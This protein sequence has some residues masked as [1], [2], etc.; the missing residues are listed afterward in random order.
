MS[1]LIRADLF[2][3]GAVIR[4]P[5]GFEKG[6]WVGA[7]GAF[8]SARERALYLTY[9]IRRPRG[10]APDRGGEARIARSTDF[11]RFEDVWSVT[12]DQFDTASIERCAVHQ[13]DD[14]QWRYFLSMVDPADGR[15]CVS[16][17]HASSP[18]SFEPARARRLF[19]A[20]EL[21]LEGA[22]DPWIRKT[23]HGFSMYLSVAV[24][25]PKTSGQSH[26]T[27]DIFNTGDC[28]SATALA[29]STDLEN[30]SW[31]GVVFT[32]SESGWDKYCRR[33]NCILPHGRA[34]YDGSASERENYEERTGLARAAGPLEWRTETP[35]GPILTSPHA[36]GSL[37][38][39]DAVEVDGRLNL[40]YEFARADGAHD[41]R[42]LRLAAGETIF[43]ASPVSEGSI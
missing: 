30:W 8:Y 27:L 43:Q 42:M 11:T 13:G 10:V 38:Y 33:L 29:T 24:P 7:P 40:F 2:S 25:T 18:G 16:V 1:N 31:Q 9:R 21:G 26:A 28:V 19:S 41:L 6:Y 14:G 17:I 22:K 3:A 35:G 20:P 12:K 15:W 4:E 34:F 39:I 23:A 5:A 37:R 32:P 36:S